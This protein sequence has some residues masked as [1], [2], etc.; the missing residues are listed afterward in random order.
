MFKWVKKDPLVH[1]LVIILTPLF[2]ILLII[3]GLIIYGLIQLFDPN[4]EEFG[5]TIALYKTKDCVELENPSFSASESC[6]VYASSI[7]MYKNKPPSL[8]E[9]IQRVVRGVSGRFKG[10]SFNPLDSSQ[11]SCSVEGKIINNIQEKV[12]EKK[13]YKCWSK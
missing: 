12:Q 11:W 1:W 2:I 13:I 8:Y 10:I 9:G 7:G 6:F 3:V 5:S 4:Y